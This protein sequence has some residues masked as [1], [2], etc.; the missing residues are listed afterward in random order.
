[1]FVRNAESRQSFGKPILIELRIDFRH[2]H[3]SDVR[4][5]ADLSPSQQ[6]SKLF[7]ASVRMADGEEWKLHTSLSCI[8]EG[9]ALVGCDMVGFVAFDF[10][11]GILFR[12]VMD[13]TLIVEVAGMDRYD[14]PRYPTSF[15]I[16]AY[17]IADLEPLRHLGKRL[18]SFRSTS[19]YDRGVVPL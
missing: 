13:M 14:G 15:R 18:V 12:G 5:N 4:D 17:V 16:P 8:V 6:L 1:M 10:V 7:E 9:T 2:R 3:F 11:L 19:Q